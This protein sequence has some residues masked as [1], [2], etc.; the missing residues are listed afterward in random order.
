[1]SKRLHQES[2]GFTA[3][4]LPIVYLDF[5]TSTPWIFPG[6][7][8]AGMNRMRAGD[9]LSPH[10]PAEGWQRVLMGWSVAA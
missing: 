7:L 8:G 9:D 4:R 5:S 10:G 1:L 6:N 3:R 2:A